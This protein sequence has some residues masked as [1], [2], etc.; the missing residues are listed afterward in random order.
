MSNK[1]LQSPNNEKAGD[2]VAVNLNNS[3]GGN[4]NLPG[5]ANT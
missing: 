1:I 5:S 4:L 3:L 2:S